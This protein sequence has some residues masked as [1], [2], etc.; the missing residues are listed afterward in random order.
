LIITTRMAKVTKEANIIIATKAA[1]ARISA[2]RCTHFLL[3][4]FLPQLRL[5]PSLSSASGS[6]QF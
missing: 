3:A 4:S 2:V 5:K 6:A 1:T